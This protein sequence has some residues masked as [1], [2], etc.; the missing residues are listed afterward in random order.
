MWIQLIK[1]KCHPTGE[2]GPQSDMTDIFITKRGHVD[3][4]GEC[5]EK[6]GAMLPQA[7][8]YKADQQTTRGWA[9]GV[10]HILPHSLRRNQPCQHPDIRHQP[11]KL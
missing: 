10:E 7:K 11:P 9:G 4:L 1:L 8:E 5:H 3:T 6:P 2:C